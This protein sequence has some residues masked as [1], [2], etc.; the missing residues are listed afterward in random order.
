MPLKRMLEEG[1]SFDPKATALLI[2][3]FDA[4]VAELDLRADDDREKAARIV[5]RLAH[6]QATL[7]AA[8]LRDEGVRL[9]RKGG[10]RGRRRPF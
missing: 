1:R 6:G 10:A 8:K 3:A 4:I 9:M 2:E 7:E 5:I